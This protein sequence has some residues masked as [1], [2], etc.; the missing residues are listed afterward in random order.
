MNTASAF[1]GGAP[2]GAANPDSAR[3]CTACHFDYDAI[4]DSKSLSIEGL[5][6]APITASTYELRVSFVDSEALIA[7]FQMLAS[8]GEFGALQKYME[9]AGASIRS[10]RPAANI[11]GIGWSILWTAPDLADKKVTFYLAVTGA[12]D[13]GSPFGDRIH[14]RS[15][16]VTPYREPAN[17]DH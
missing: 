11:N 4:P 6:V 15:F 7:G 14:F 1:P 12:N 10:T 3:S 5:P 16:T 8:A 9:S 13:D 17:T 2:W